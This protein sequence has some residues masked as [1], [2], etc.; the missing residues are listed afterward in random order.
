MAEPAFRTDPPANASKGGPSSGANQTG[1]FLPSTMSRRRR[2]STVI[3]I[4]P[5]PL[6]PFSRNGQS[7][8][9]NPNGTKE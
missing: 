4:A 3:D 5:T 1:T 8:A 7:F 9:D 2:Y 6:P